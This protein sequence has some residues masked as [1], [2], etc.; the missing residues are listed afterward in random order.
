VLVVR[1]VPNMSDPRRLDE[2]TIFNDKLTFLIPHEWIEAE[3][4]EDGTY[5]YQAS[6]ARSGWFR[7]SLVTIDNV[8][9]P[10]ERLEEIFSDDKNVS[11][12]EATGNLIRRTEKNSEEHGVPLH[13]FYWFVGGCVP[14]HCVYKAVFSYT[15]LS[16]VLNNDDTQA[17]VRLLEQ[18]VSEAR[19]NPTVRT[20]G[21]G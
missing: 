15:V 10:A 4:G 16:D 3:S 12:N 20:N 7:V 5:L 19:F 9:K 13:I 14:P 18:L 17:E 1:I 6:D 8:A 2:V 11:A 21:R